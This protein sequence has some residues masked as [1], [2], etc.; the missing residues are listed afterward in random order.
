MTG[1]GNDNSTGTIR[2]TVVA[3]P[4][5]D[6]ATCPLEVLV[7]E[8]FLQRQLTTEMERLAMGQAPQP[9]LARTILRNLCRDLA[10]HHADETESLFPRLR[11]RAA[12]EDEIEPLLNRLEAEH[13]AAGKSIAPLIPALVCMADGALPTAEDRAALCAM[14]Q[15]ER[16]HLIVENAIVLPL[17]RMRLTAA[18]K[19]AMREEMRARRLAPP[20]PCPACIGPLQRLQPGAE[21][22][23]P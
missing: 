10:L 16:R 2:G 18:D 11:R 9:A 19:A 7:E 8:H 5:I 22:N 23:T 6:T 14:A 4:Q 1:P 13:V 3:R 12:P 15:S 17:A 21:G 20:P